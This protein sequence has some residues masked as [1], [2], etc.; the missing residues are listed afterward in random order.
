[1]L[2]LFFFLITA[3]LASIAAPSLTNAHGLLTTESKTIGNY[4]IQY[5]ITADGASIYED[6]P[7]TYAF[8]LLSK[9]GKEQIPYESA[10]VGFL[11]KGGNVVFGAQLTGPGE[12]GGGVQLEAAMPD[13][14]EYTVQVN[15]KLPKN[16][17]VNNE[18]L[19]ANF[20]FTVQG[21]SSSLQ[22]TKNTPPFPNYVLA[23]LA[24]IVG[25]SLGRFGHKLLGF[26]KS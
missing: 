3:L 19:S 16:A 12:F 23:I 2:K 5:A 1:M 24:L 18:D 22:T 21:D 13:P 17:T 20:D 26:L 11:K 10:S 15:F 6:F 25:I 14:G 8:Q 4:Q 9:D 7:L